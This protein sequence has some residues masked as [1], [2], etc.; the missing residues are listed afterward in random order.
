MD[1]AL[2]NKL[3]NLSPQQLKE[4][5]K[6]MGKERKELPLIPR[7][8][9]QQYP[10]TGAQKRMWFLSKLDPDSYLY[11]NPI[12]IRIKAKGSLDIDLYVHG[13][14]KV[15]QRHEIMRTSFFSKEGQIMQQI[16][17]EVAFTIEKI[18]L[19]PYS[20]TEKQAAVDEILATD[21]KT[22]IRIE[23]FP[24]FKFKLLVL[25]A[26]E[27]VLLYTSHH[28]I[29][30]AWSSSAIFREMQEIYEQTL[31]GKGDDMTPLKYQ[32]VDYV[33]W[34]QTWPQSEEYRQTLSKWKSL[35]PA[36][37]E[38]LNLPADY[39]RPA[40][41]H[42][43][44]GLEK[45]RLHPDFVH[46]LHEFSKK[47]GVNLFHTLLAGF[48]VLL[49]YY[50]R[51]EEIVVGI[52]LANRKL[53]EFQRTVGMFLNTLPHRT[54]MDRAASFRTYLQQV[55]SVSQEMVIHQDFPFEKLVEE[56]NP[57]RDLSIA[58][59]FQVLFVF[60]NIPDMYQWDDLEVAPIK[61]DY[62]ISKYELN[63]WIEEVAG[64]LFLSMTYQTRLFKKESIALF[65]HYYTEM[66]ATLMDCPELPISDL[67]PQ[68]QEISGPLS[69]WLQPTDPYIRA[70]EKHAS[71]QG[72][73]LALAYDTVCFSYR[74]LNE[75][76]NQL[77][78]YLGQFNKMKPLIA[79]LLP[80]SAEQLISILAIHKAGGAYLPIDPGITAERLSM[81]LDEADVDL[82]I[83]QSTYLSLFKNTSVKCV[84]LDDDRQEIEQCRSDD[85][86]IVLQPQDLAYVLYT[87]GTTGISKGVCIEHA[88]LSNYAQAIWQRIGLPSNSRFATVSG[89]TTDLGNTQIFPALMHG[90]AVDMVPDAYITNPALLA[91]YT[92]EHAI[93]CLK[94]VPSL[95]TSLL[96][97]SNAAA[98][99]PRKLLILG[100]EKTTA[101]LVNEIRKHRPELRIIN[102]YG[103]TETT[104]GI[105]TYE[106]GAVP[107][108][109]MIPLGV[110][111]DNNNVFIMDTKGRVLPEGM[112]GE[113]VISGLNVGRGYHRNEQ[114][115]Q[116]VF[117]ADSERTMSRTYRTG[118]LGRKNTD[119]TISFLGRIDRQV[120]I[121]GF[122][123]EPEAVERT[124]L[125]NPDIAQAVVLEQEGRLLAYVVLVESAKL[126]IAQLKQQLKSLL[127]VYMVPDEITPLPQ[128]PRL[129]NGKINIRA[130]RAYKAIGSDTIMKAI[131]PRDEVEL[132]I[133]R[134]WKE[135]LKV[136]SI[137]VTDNFFEVGGTSLAA[138]EFVAKL[139]QLFDI[140]LGIGILFEYNTIQSLA[141]LVKSGNHTSHN[142]S[143]VLLKKG[144][145]DH[146]LFFVHPAGGDVF[147]YYELASKIDPSFHVYGLQSM[148]FNLSDKSI[149]ALAERY[150]DAIKTE[151][152]KGEYVFGGWSMGAYVA[153]EMAQQ[154]H[155]LTHEAVPVILL[156]QRAPG[157]AEVNAG[158]KI[159]VLERQVAFARKIEHL[160]GKKNKLTTHLLESLSVTD[161]T[162]LF[163]EAF[164][165]S[166]LVP[167]E[168]E[169]HQFQGFLD[170]MM[171]HH[172]ITARYQANHYEGPVLLIKA[173]DSTAFEET[174]PAY[175]DCYGWSVPVSEHLQTDSVPGN[176]V[177]IMRP[178]YAQAVAIKINETLMKGKAAAL[179]YAPI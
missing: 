176:H 147:S 146:Y 49:H 59:I 13:F 133:S 64:G 130:L 175:A 10:V 38:P 54:V 51:N 36:V 26:H 66:L 172:D 89:I 55:K 178:P 2:K 22:P 29:S 157:Q 110:P 76:A 21:G 91:N 150:L 47:E 16:H 154:W 116:T 156:D 65:L 135:L 131:A 139:N 98:V 84:L 83:T 44:G 127:P 77:A 31:A 111:L 144:T 161:R 129:S 70:F 103:P 160:T 34:E 48:N 39:V 125:R 81:L 46:Q 61:P 32:F 18:D 41:I 115:T 164:K 114:L 33:Y 69:L 82:V 153:Y 30:D 112:P 28:I 53:K 19:Q 73:A 171:E 67:R 57:P 120:K 75:K 142:S 128:L 121:R 24:L 62:H 35:L 101:S 137:S 134:M 126:G 149:H 138:I 52:P 11:T 4:L 136:N 145:S 174:D 117:S 42:Y 179:T 20:E 124:I 170:K 168:L 167:D 23:D 177:S 14:R 163:L 100:G 43:E 5:M 107:P 119:G 148:D 94:I 104:I 1:Q 37:P 166:H 45:T 86:D 80:R 143:L 25:S 9:L 6:K 109:S 87:S 50:S 74:Q 71:A 102:H 162:G 90:A 99:L 155:T 92:H 78:H 93:D 159:S 106:I 60:Q 108:E 63:L 158:E 169:T 85:P 165:E 151:I 12:G 132:A 152:P 7:N 56:L 113:I 96:R 15:V 40:V 105:L 72:D 58:P 3:T 79:F 8:E 95:L 88:Q 122:R 118:D 173:A 17:N 27:F 97:T 123:V 140:E 68:K 141:L